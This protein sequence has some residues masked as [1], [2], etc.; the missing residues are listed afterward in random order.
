MSLLD[1][2]RALDLSAI[3]SARG[4]ISAA[5]QA[6]E[7][8]AVLG[9]GAAQTALAG[10]GQSLASFRGEFGDPA[11]LLAPVVDAVGALRGVFATAGL[12]LDRYVSA[13]G[14]GV[15]IAVQLVDGLDR[16]PL[17][18]GRAFGGSLGDRLGAL[19]RLFESYAP[20]DAGALGQLMSGLDALDRG[21]TRQ[22]LDLAHFAIDVLLPFPR[23][24]LLDI[25][26]ALDTV[27]SATAAIS[28]PAGRLTG[29]L[30]AL[31]A[32]NA[33]AVAADRAA[34]DRALRELARVRAN[35]LEVLQG[36]LL[37][38]VE[39]LG[40]LQLGHLLDPVARASAAV[41]VGRDSVL[42]F[43]DRLRA[44]L[45]E[46]R[47]LVEQADAAVIADFL[48][49]VV[50][51][52]R[53]E[54]QARI[55]APIEAQVA[56]LEEFLRDLFR[57]LPLRSIRA[58]ITRFLHSVAQAVQDAGLDRVAR[59]VH[60]ALATVRSALSAEGLTAEVQQALQ[61][62]AA[63]VNDAL[64]G[65]VAPMESIGQAIDGVAAQAREV[66][67]RA[68]TALAEFADAM[69]AATDAIENLGVDAA[70]DEVVQTL[71]QLRE[72]AEAL[73]SVAPLPESMRPVVEQL[74]STLENIDF[75]TV[76]QPVR[77]AVSQIQIPP[78][79][80]AQ[81]RETLAKVKEALDHVIPAELIASVEAEITR[82]LDVIR[83]FDPSSL[84][85]GVGSFLDEAAQFVESLDPR[86]I[87]TQIRAPFQAVLDAVDAAQPRRLL[88]PVIDAYDA[89]LA[90]VQLPSPDLAI[91]RFGE[92]VDASGE[93]VGQVVAAPAQRLLGPGGTGG[94]AATG[95][96]GGGAGGGA[97]GEA[98]TSAPAGELPFRPGDIVRLFGY[99][100][101]KLREALQALEAGPAGDVMRTIDSLTGG[102]ARDIR[103]LRADLAQLE[104]RLEQSLNESLAPLA[105]AQVRAQLGIRASFSAGGVDIDASLTAVAAAG[106]G[107]LRHEL[108]RTLEL[109]RGRV[110]DT[111]AVAGGATGAAL[112]R[113]A[114]ALDALRMSGLAGDLDDFLAALDPEPLAREMDELVLAALHRAPSLLAQVQ[115]RVEAALGRLRDLVAELNPATQAQK[116]FRVLEVLKAELDV[117]NPSVLADEL[118]EIHAAVRA[119]IAAY[120]PAVLA[121]DL[122]AALQETARSLRALDPATLLGDLHFLDGILDRVEAAVP[123]QALAGVGASLTEVGERL[124]A[125]DPGA[126]LEA[127]NQLGPRVEQAFED[128]VKKIRD[129]VVA[130][131]EAIRYA[132]ASA[133]ASV[134]GSVSV[135]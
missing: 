112:E 71:R 39:Q 11:A 73:L 94:G 59:T 127:V 134:S 84:L 33:A 85:G 36:D 13:V 68:A 52:L 65:V 89:A 47:A 87:A 6:P 35:T 5:V 58:E 60:E 116:F 10:L 4:S 17:A 77:G 130:L 109:V 1:D 21:V 92:L 28:L 131:L 114:M 50:D 22:P 56:R 76:F 132:S 26:T 88:R 45:S 129:E 69:H 111:A 70:A 107:A 82:A 100:P 61:R 19:P 64:D 80:G 20:V 115:A 31:D 40:R 97:G 98:G 104:G 101:A 91:R 117:L 110:R 96:P 27:A 124:V 2:L 53:S 55:V 95:A 38:V 54:A 51:T 72:K 79:A 103:R 30:A 15:T 57:S 25:R 49:R 108:A 46:A 90:R 3:V 12:P 123:T 75:D 14:E 125:L 133:S 23:Q 120:D 41:R 78:E 43:L 24:P 83:G 74:I 16:D 29:L 37:R 66:L 93:A 18:L 128:A 81:V 126:L 118:G 8:Q 32:V 48:D 99:V 7:L 105:H 106:P 86:P 44:Q 135:G 102:L 63:T 67:D 113:A 9:G 122:F 121:A 34:L 119:T 42:E 62:A